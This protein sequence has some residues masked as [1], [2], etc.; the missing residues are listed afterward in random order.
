MKRIISFIKHKK[1]VFLGLLF[2]VFGGV[3]AIALIAMLIVQLWKERV[4]NVPMTEKEM[5][6]IYFFIVYGMITS[7][8]VL[9]IMIGKGYHKE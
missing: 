6:I 9:V 5:E 7:G 2:F 3:P 8:T 4:F 1:N